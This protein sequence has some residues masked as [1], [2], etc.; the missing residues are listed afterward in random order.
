MIEKRITATLEPWSAKILLRYGVIGDKETAVLKPHP[1]TSVDPGEEVPEFLSLSPTI[2]QSL[3]D[4]LFECG[5][6]PTQGFGSPGQV[7]ALKNHVDDLRQIAFKATG[8]T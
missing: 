8:V 3:M 1:L 4:Q 7:E 2:A 5:V 6:R